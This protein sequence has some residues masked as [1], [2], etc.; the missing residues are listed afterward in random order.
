MKGKA[1]PPLGASPELYNC[2]FRCIRFWR[3]TYFKGGMGL[4]VIRLIATTTD[5]SAQQDQT[6]PEADKSLNLNQTFEASYM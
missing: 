5:R 1:T 3:P 4:L 6:G 2:S